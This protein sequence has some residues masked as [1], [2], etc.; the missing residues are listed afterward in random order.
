MCFDERRKRLYVFGR[1]GERGENAK[2]DFYCYDI[3]EARWTC[4][5]RDTRV[6]Q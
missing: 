1:N 5:S 3:L 6:R 2:A 4:L